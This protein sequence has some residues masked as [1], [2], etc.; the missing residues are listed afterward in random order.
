M[1]T[2]A[3]FAEAGGVSVETV[4]FYQRK[5]LLNIPSGNSGIR[6]YGAEDMRRL[7]FIRKAQAAGFPLE[8]IKELLDLDL[9]E[10]RH[11]AH[12]LAVQRLKILDAKLAELGAA[13]D[14]L[15]RLANQCGKGEAGPC[16]ILESFGV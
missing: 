2:I 12:Q 8:E 13:R 5:G 1:F 16:P 7:K 3:K 9:C 10:N 14:A 4:R 15:K 11:R 6:H